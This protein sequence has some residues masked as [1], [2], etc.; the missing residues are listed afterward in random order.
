MSRSEVCDCTE[1]ICFRAQLEGKVQLLLN[2]CKALV[3][4]SQSHLASSL[5]LDC[6]ASCKPGTF[7]RAVLNQHEG[8]KARPKLATSAMPNNKVLDPVRHLGSRCS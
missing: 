6:H 4:L 7:I 2:A 3:E 1:Y 5:H 8:L